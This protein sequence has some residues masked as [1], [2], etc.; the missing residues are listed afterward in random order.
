MK[1]LII[2]IS[3][4]ISISCSAQELIPHVHIYC[5]PNTESDL[6]GYK[7]HFFTIPATDTSTI[8]IQLNPSYIFFNKLAYNVSYG[9]FITAL[10]SSGN[11]SIPSN[12]VTFF[13][14]K[15]TTNPHK[16]KLIRIEK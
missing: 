3:L 5:T 10:D 14:H 2:T 1:K 15:D 6:A 4:L 9:F 13:A 11:E 16:P 8:T 12:T 7:I